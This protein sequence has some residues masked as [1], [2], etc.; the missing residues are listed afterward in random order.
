M[1]PQ[2]PNQPAHLLLCC[3]FLFCSRLTLLLQS[4]LFV[5][6][7]KYLSCFKA[8]FPLLFKDLRN[9]RKVHLG[10]FCIPGVMLL[11]IRITACLFSLKQAEHIFRYKKLDMMNSSKHLLLLFCHIHSGFMVLIN[12]LTVKISTDLGITV[13]EVPY[14]HNYYASLWN[15][16]L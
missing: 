9:S 16:R 4:C 11:L 15:T 6:V 10:W 2:S 7:F 12:L 13:P 8:S 14:K 1:F 5:C 3:S